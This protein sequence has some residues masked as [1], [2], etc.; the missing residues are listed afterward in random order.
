MSMTNVDDDD[1]CTMMRDGRIPM[2]PQL[3]AWVS[4]NVTLARLASDEV[5]ETCVKPGYTP[6]GYLRGVDESELTVGVIDDE[7]LTVLR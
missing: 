1:E 7:M 6:T 5:T 4:T 3:E 2:V